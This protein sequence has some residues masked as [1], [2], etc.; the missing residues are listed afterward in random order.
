MKKKINIQFIIITIVAIITTVS[1]STFVFYKL[2]KKEVMESIKTNCELII[3][4][5]SEH[6]ISQPDNIRE[7]AF[8]DCI[9]ELRITL[10]AADGTAVY[11]SDV[12]TSAME[13]HKERPEVIAAINNGYGEAV[14]KSHTIDKNSFYYAKRLDNGYVLRV[15]KEA[16]S[17]TSVFLSVIPIIGFICIILFIICIMLSHFLT[18]SIIQPIEDMADNLDSSENINVYKELNPFVDTIRKQHADIMRNANMRQEF[19][20]NVSHE[21]KTPLTSISGYSELIES[22]M[23]TNDDVIRFASEIHKNSKRLLT[24]INDILRLSQLDEAT[25]DDVF[26]KINIY[27]I[28]QS[29]VEMLQMTA[30][31]N[32]VSITVSGSTQYIYANRQMM[33][34]LIYNLCDNAIRYNNPGGSVHVSVTKDNSDVI[35]EVKDNGIGI[36]KEN[37]QRIF[38]RFYRVDKSRSKQTGGTGLGLAIVKHIVARHENARLE[39]E[40]EEEKGTTIRVI[41]KTDNM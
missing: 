17:I 20:A 25:S 14:R 19:T 5:D 23:A 33:D 34:E 27:D 28:A 3:D 13:N 7:N 8:G 16:G 31:K 29:S 9:N 39:L 21:L 1:L 2:F 6:I 30:D 41:F 38:E 36:S 11:D 10:I 12:A 26:E 24:L 4:S 18:K 35:V 15:S 37:Q 22:G 32:N 40:S